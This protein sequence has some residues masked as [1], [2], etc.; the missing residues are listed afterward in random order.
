MNTGAFYFEIT[1]KNSFTKDDLIAIENAKRKIR[2]AAQRGDTYCY[3]P[4]NA[5]AMKWLKLEGFNIGM[6]YGNIFVVSW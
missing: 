1:G 6:D 4:S 3:V 5:Y 2:E